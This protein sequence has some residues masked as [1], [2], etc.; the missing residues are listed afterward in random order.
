MKPRAG[1][2]VILFEKKVRWSANETT[3]TPPRAHSPRRAVTVGTGAR[4]HLA[5]VRRR[6][7]QSRR[8]DAPAPPGL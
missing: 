2:N 1:C 8:S 3:T 4:A 6:R 7:W 5:P